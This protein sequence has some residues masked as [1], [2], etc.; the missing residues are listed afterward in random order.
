MVSTSLSC[1]RRSILKVTWAAVAG[2][3]D[4][5]VCHRLAAVE[6]GLGFLTVQVEAFD[7]CYPAAVA[8]DP[9]IDALIRVV[10]SPGYRKLLGELPGYDATPAG[11]MEAV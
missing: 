9:R 1:S 3:A 6:A 4:I 8:G 11:E 7:L 5:G 10:R 2:W